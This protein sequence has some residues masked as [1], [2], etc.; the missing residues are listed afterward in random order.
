MFNFKGVKSITFEYF[1]L[2]EILNG[3]TGNILAEKEIPDFLRDAIEK[4]VPVLAKG[5]GGG[6]Q[7]RLVWEN[8][9]F[10]FNKYEE[11]D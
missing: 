4:G 8:N 1:D 3:N 2:V 6:L 10:K 5:L 11:V 7:Y 9:T